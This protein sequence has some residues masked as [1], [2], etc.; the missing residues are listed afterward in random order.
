L[1]RVLVDEICQWAK[2]RLV[3]LLISTQIDHKLRPMH[4]NQENKWEFWKKLAV[5]AQIQEFQ[6]RLDEATKLFM[7]RKYDWEC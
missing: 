7:V 6:S 3:C 4:G 2:A 5:D 1:S